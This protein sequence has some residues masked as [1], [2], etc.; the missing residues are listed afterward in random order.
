MKILPCIIIFIVALLI[1]FFL[2]QAN[3]GNTNVS[4]KRK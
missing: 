1:L 2:R 4:P 3:G